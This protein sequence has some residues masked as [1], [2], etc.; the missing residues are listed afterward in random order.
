MLSYYL[1]YFAL[2]HIAIK[3]TQY[4][5]REIAIIIY[6]DKKVELSFCI[7]DKLTDNNPYPF[8][9]K[10]KIFTFNIYVF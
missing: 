10:F 6:T 7:S 8:Y 4:K 9:H 2:V 5:L 3:N 1:K